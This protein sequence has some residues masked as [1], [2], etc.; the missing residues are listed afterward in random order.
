MLMSRSTT[1][2]PSPVRATKSRTD[3][4]GPRGS[5]AL[6]HLARRLVD[7]L[8]LA[9]AQADGVACRSLAARVVL[10]GR[11]VDVDRQDPDAVALGVVDDDRGRVE[12]HRLVVQHADGVVRRPV[13][14]QPG[15]VV[16]DLGEGGG[17]GTGEAELGE[18]G[19]L[20]RRA[21]RHRSSVRP[22]RMAPPTNRRR[23]AC[24]LAWLRWRAHRLAEDVGLDR[25]VAADLDGDLHD[26]LLVEDHAQRVGQDR[27]EAG[28]GVGDRLLAGAPSQVRDAR[29]CPAPGR[30]G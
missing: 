4:Y 5:L 1:C 20:L 10:P 2:S 14:L 27:L 21:R 26:L 18:G 3:V 25:G 24:I 11:L 12:A 23:S 30:A 17:V 6:E 15:G 22:V 7:P 13:A 8:H 29:R 9:Q 16:G 28:M 19:A